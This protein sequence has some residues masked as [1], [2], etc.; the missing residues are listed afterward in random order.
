[1]T[2]TTSVAR[3]QEQ[4]THRTVRLWLG[5]LVTVWL[6]IQ[7]V[8]VIFSYFQALNFRKP[9]GNQYDEHRIVLRDTQAEYYRA[10][11]VGAGTAALA[12]VF[13]AGAVGLIVAAKWARPVLAVGANL[14][15]VF[16]IATQIWQA[17]LP[18]DPDSGLLAGGSVGIMGAVMGI[19]LWNIIPVGILILALVSKPSDS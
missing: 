2:E 7:V 16:T 5:A 9:T 14:Q 17:M 10:S 13:I 18:E 11:A 1:M 4:P 19:F 8:A 6:L 3:N 15:I 12:V